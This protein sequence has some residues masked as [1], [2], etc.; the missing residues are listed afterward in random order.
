TLESVPELSDPYP[1][2]A[3]CGRTILKGELV[4]E[5]VNPQ[6]QRLGVCVLCRARAE[7][8]G[9]IPADQ[10]GTATQAPP[11]RARPGDA[12]RKRLERAAS[13][14]RSSARGLRG[15]AATL[16]A[17][18]REPEKGETSAKRHSAEPAQRPQRPGAEPPAKGPRPQS[19]RQPK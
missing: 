17:P 12:L 2:C 5:Y 3:V 6:G 18:P 13:R 19:K 15:D 9:W 7:A 11:S 10:A 1:T 16:E 14:A 4:H 8:S